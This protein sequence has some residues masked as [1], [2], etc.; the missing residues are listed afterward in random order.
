MG[1]SSLWFSSEKERLNAQTRAAAPGEFIALTDG[2]T[3]YEVAGPEGGQPVVLVHGFS[4]PYHIWDPTFEALVEADFRVLRYDLLGRGYSDRPKLAYTRTLF[5]K[6]LFELIHG[7]SMSPPVD[8]IGL[9]MGGAI[10]AVFTARH[11]EWVRKLV[12]IDPAGVPLKQSPAASL[13]Q[14]PGIGELCMHLF[15]DWFFLSS[16][17]K[18]YAQVIDLDAYEAKYRVQMRFG[19][20]K[21]ALLSTL[22]NGLPTD[23]LEEYRQIGE[24]DRPILLIWGK[25]D[26]TV[27][28][29][30]S[31]LVRSL[32]PEAAFYAIDGAAHLPHIEKAD[33]VNPLILH[34]LA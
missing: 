13:I 21:R 6:Q 12:L 19:G 24:R 27:P 17:R 22:R 32:L 8:L 25:E 30:Q 28:F 33:H 23:A 1:M 3:H 9:S 7:L 14:L 2:V 16:L 26:R 10:S 31:A 20:F 34:F 15:G 29:E 4:V 5:D 18:D 11:P